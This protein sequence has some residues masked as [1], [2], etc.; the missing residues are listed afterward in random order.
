MT[1]RAR[2]SGVF[3]VKFEN[4]SGVGEVLPKFIH[5]VVT[6]K[7]V[8]AKGEDMRLGKDD[9]HLTVTI[10]AGLRREGFDI[11][12]MTVLATERLPRRRE[13]VRF[14]REPQRFMREGVFPHVGQRG[15]FAAML[16]VT[17]IAGKRGTL[18]FDRAV[19]FCHVEHLRRNIRMTGRTAVRHGWSA[20]RKNM[21][22]RTCGNLGM[23]SHTAVCVALPS[24]QRARRKHLSAA[25]NGKAQNR[26]G[27]DKDGNNS[28][29]RETSKPVVLHGFT[30]LSNVA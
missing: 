20:Q 13:L 28:R 11:L 8:F 12:V 25:E 30:Y 4:K 1:F 19:Q 27:G 6:G 26:A 5:A 21:A 9:I 2:Q 22:I 7:T 24:I 18:L 16:R 17:I 3:A 23:R 15:G 29:D 14:Q 10:I